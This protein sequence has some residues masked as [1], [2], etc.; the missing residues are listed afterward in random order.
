MKWILA[1]GLTAVAAQQGDPV[2]H[3]S[4]EPRHK[5]VFES[6]TTRVQDVQIPADDTSLYHIHDHALV[7]VPLSNSRIRTQQ[8]GQ[9]WSGGG[10]ARDGAGGRSGGASVQSD[11]RSG[12][13]PGAPSGAGRVTTN[14]SYPQAPITHRVGNVGDNLYRLIAIGNLSTGSDAPD[15]DVSG[16]GST[17][18]ILNRYYRVFRVS[19][20]SGQ[21]TAVHKHAWPVVVVQ[22]TAGRLTID[23]ASAAQTTEPG[24]FAFFDATGSHTVKN[25]GPTTVDVIEVELRG[26]KAR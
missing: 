22:Q 2:V 19:L 1:F 20:P 9:E 24:K 11:G 13:A 10:A 17:P 5:V 21:S 14:T 3:M 23:A 15:D 26:G 25:T 12:A 7:Y 4:K 16:L 8:L 6:G 18:E